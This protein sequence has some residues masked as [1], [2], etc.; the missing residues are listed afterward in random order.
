MRH[1][2]ELSVFQQ[3]N[4]PRQNQV[5]SACMNTI[6]A[7]FFATLL[8]HAGVKSVELQIP[9][10]TNVVNFKTIRTFAYSKNSPTICANLH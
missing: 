10:Q 8:D 2:R 5:G 3:S 4:A 6:T 7:L 9:L 1:R